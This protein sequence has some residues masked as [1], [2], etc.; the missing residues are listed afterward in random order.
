MLSWASVFWAAA[1]VAAALALVLAKKLLTPYAWE[2][3]PPTLV[4][5]YK[6]LP[7]TGMLLLSAYPAVHEI[8]ALSCHGPTC[9]PS[10]I[11]QQGAS[12]AAVQL[13]AV[14]G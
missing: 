4:P 3:D 10:G 13:V 12:V 5:I 11:A 2:S 14:F 6:P 8:H 7:I 9:C 1:A